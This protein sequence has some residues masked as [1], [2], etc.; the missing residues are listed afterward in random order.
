MG[1]TPPSSLRIIPFNY[2]LGVVWHMFFASR[3]VDGAQGQGGAVASNQGT[4]GKR[5]FADLPL[6]DTKCTATVIL[7]KMGPGLLVQLVSPV[8]LQL[9]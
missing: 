4:F 3:A 6:Q 1:G 8:C 2:A 9:I 7:C 5:S